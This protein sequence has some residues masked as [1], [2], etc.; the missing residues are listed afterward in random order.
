MTEGHPDGLMILL[1]IG[2]AYFLP[3]IVALSRSHQSW[4]AI[5]AVN[6]LRGWTALGW[7]V[8]FI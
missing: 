3:S 4:P 7:L 2:F 5:L 6:V 1:I 8:A